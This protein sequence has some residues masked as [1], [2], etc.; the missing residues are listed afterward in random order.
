MLLIY[1]YN[2]KII[3]IVK[4]VYI[5][6]SKLNYNLSNKI[7]IITKFNKKIPSER[8]ELSIEKVDL[9]LRERALAPLSHIPC[10]IY[11]TIYCS[12]FM[13]YSIIHI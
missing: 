2:N 9:L 6:S 7:Y 13:T 5:N 1:L 11:Y 3:Y 8:F 12:I 4:N 10:F